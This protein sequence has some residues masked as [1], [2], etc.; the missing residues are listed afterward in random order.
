MSLLVSGDEYEVPAQQTTTLD[1]QSGEASV[2]ADI[3]HFSQ[4]IVKYAPLFVEV[5]DPANH[6]V[7]ETF[8]ETGTIGT[9]RW[10]WALSNAD[11]VVNADTLDVDKLDWT[12]GPH[13]SPG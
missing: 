1:V 7:S 2:D 8:A 12:S 11:V 3:A 13:L 6:A 9:G 4:L 10:A 5:K